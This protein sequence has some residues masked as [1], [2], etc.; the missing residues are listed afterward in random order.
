MV[1]ADV[2]VTGLRER[3]FRLLH[4]TAGPA[5]EPFPVPDFLTAAQLAGHQPARVENAFYLAEFGFIHE[6]STAKSSRFTS[7][8]ERGV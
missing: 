3:R 4:Q 6:R 1:T 2:A 7:P 8:S 5:I